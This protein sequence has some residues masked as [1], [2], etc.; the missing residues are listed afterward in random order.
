MLEN[1]LNGTPTFYKWDK[2][3]VGAL[4][5]FIVP[6]LGLAGLFLIT[7]LNAKLNHH[8][9]FTPHMFWVSMQSNIAFMRIATLCCMLNGFLFFFFVKKD[10]NN[11]CRGVIVITLL[12]ALGIAIKEI[13]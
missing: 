12:F 10:Y 13:M 5:A 4:P 6:L 3:W 7:L 8:E 11:A 2:F 1:Y 9:D